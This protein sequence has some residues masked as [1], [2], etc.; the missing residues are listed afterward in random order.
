MSVP[1]RLHLVRHKDKYFYYKGLSIL[2]MGIQVKRHL[3][4]GGIAKYDFD[5]STLGTD[6]LVHVLCRK[7]SARSKASVCS[8]YSP[9]LRAL[10]VGGANELPLQR[11]PALQQQ[12][13]L[14]IDFRQTQ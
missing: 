3:P 6:P 10:R 11:F 5:A 9:Y 14:F 8:F 7:L 2:D 13:Q 4:S 12:Q 1:D